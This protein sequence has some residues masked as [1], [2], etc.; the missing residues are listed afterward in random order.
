MTAPSAVSPVSAFSP[1]PGCG[2]QRDVYGLLPELTGARI[3]PRPPRPRGRRSA[4]PTPR[5]TR[6]LRPAG[7]REPLPSHSTSAVLRFKFP[8]GTFPFRWDDELAVNLSLRIQSQANITPAKDTFEKEE[9][10]AD[11]VG[12]DF[13]RAHELVLAARGPW[14]HT[15]ILDQ[16]RGGR[17]RLHADF[18]ARRHFV[19]RFPNESM[20]K[21]HRPKCSSLGWNSFSDTLVYA[22]MRDLL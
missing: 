17:A 15:P 11:S 8:L 4:Q 18:F 13:R 5:R 14:F 9:R 20:L 22:L 3:N 12:H 19:R 21:A 7:D 6:G 16:G 1:G 2:L 10:R